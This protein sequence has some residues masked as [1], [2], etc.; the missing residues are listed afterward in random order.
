M[1]VCARLERSV[2]PWADWVLLASR[3]SIIDQRRDETSALGRRPEAASSS[4][5][6][7][8]QHENYLRETTL[9]TQTERN[10]EGD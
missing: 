9:L 7:L 4:Q 8:L 3:S 2:L 5:T 6:L 10:G 1:H